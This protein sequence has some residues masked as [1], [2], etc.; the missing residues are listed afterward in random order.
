VLRSISDS[1]FVFYFLISIELVYG[2]KMA[3]SV[4][5]I[6]EQNLQKCLKLKLYHWFC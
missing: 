4:I 5:V 1:R 6:T 3:L 2:T